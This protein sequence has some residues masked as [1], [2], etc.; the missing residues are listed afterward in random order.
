MTGDDHKTGNGQ[1]VAGESAREHVLLTVLGKSPQPVRYCL[2]GEDRVR[3][4]K[5]APLALY[6]LLAPPARPDRVA[7]LCTP[8]AE[9]QSWPLLETEL[10]GRCATELVRVP[11]GG[12]REDIDKYIEQVAVAIPDN[13]DITVDVTHGFRHFS[14]LMYVAVLYLV[15]L[16]GVTV[17]GAYY[18]MLNSNFPSPFIDL[19]P[20]LELPRWVYALEVLRDTGSTLPMAK[21]LRDGRENQ[22][23]KGI[24]RDLTRL[25]ETYLSALPLEF[26]RLARDL[27]QRRRPLRRLLGQN[28][29]LPLALAEELVK[30][31][32]DILEPYAIDKPVPGD[33][34]KRK[35]RLCA[36]E[37]KRQAGIID[38]LLERENFATAFRL[39]REWLVSWAV[40]QQAP[41]DEWLD[42]DVRKRAERILHAIRAI[43][44]DQDLGGVLTEKQRQLGAFWKDLTGVR[45]AYAHHGMRRGDLVQDPK[46]AKV[47]DRVVEC[48][49]YTFRSSPAIFLSIGESS[50]RRVLVSP[51]GRR[52]GVLFSAVQAVRAQH[53]EPALCLVIASHKT[54]GMIA[55]ALGR[56]EFSGQCE[57]LVM[58][59]AFAGG[60]AEV[61]RVAKAARKHLVGAAEVV[62]NVTG[63]TTLMGLGAE[64]LAAEAHSLACPVRRFGLIDRRSTQQQDTDPYQAGEPFWLDNLKD[65]DGD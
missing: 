7:A 12:T 50:G 31:L 20:L 21:N 14:F 54:E 23:T 59:D 3:E 40:H 29:R 62:V 10:K 16:R 13:T 18:G 47:R 36:N 57:L 34:W 25:S 35:I 49:K 53:G 48:W 64:K 46:A 8:E 1:T 24:A 6:K 61:E 4:A 56:A 26:G 27:A 9:Q 41:D 11:A 51:I 32:A 65:H 44:D 63:G 28:Y 15:A 19:R 2:E 17:R 33:G 42:R 30:R 37:L 55:Q 5:L 38:S 60:A 45:N 58:E 39:M 52:P 43:R 22:T